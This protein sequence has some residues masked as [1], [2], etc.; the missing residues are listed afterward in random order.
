MKTITCIFSFLV[1]LIVTE[2]HGQSEITIRTV[3]LT[4][5]VAPGTD[6]AVFQTLSGG[7]EFAPALNNTG[8][9]AFNGELSGPGVTSQNKWGIWKEN[10]ELHLVVRGGDI[11]PGT[12]G[13]VFDPNVSV[14]SNPDLNDSSHV[15]FLSRLR[16]SSFDD[17][18]LSVWKENPDLQ[19]VAREGDVA[20]GTGGATFDG[21]FTWPSI[22]NS[23]NVGFQNRVLGPT[24]TSNNSGMWKEDPDLQLIVRTGDEAPG[25]DGAIFSDLTFAA[26]PSLTNANKAAFRGEFTEPGGNSGNQTGLWRETPS[27]ELIVRRFDIAPGTDGALFAY[28]T[29]GLY[30]PGSFAS[31]SMNSS[32][33]VAFFA[34]LDGP[35][36]TGDNRRSVWKERSGLELVVR[37]GDLAPGT[38]GATF[39]DFFSH[40]IAPSFN[41]KGDV[42]FGGYLYGD[43]VTDT[44]DRGIWVEAGSEGMVLVLRRGDE[45][46][47]RPGDIRTV[48]FFNL[49][50]DG[51]NNKGDVAFS[52]QFEDGSSG[53]FVASRSFLGGF[54]L[55]DI[56]GD[57]IADLIWRN[58]DSG[59][60]ATWLMNDLGQRQAAT[61]PGGAGADWAIQGVGDVNGDGQGDVVWRNKTSGATAVWLMNA[62]GNREAATFPGGASFEWAIR[63]VGDVNNDGFA[64]VVWRNTSSGATAV[65]LMNEDGLREAAT[66]PGGAGGEWVIQG[67]GDVN[68]D[69]TVDIVWRN[70]SSG[71]TAAW[72]MNTDGLRQMASFPGGVVLAWTIKGIEDVNG[73]GVGDLVWRDTISGATAVWLMDSSGLRQKAV[74]PGGAGN[75]WA[76]QQVGDVNG[77]NRADLVWRNIDTGATATW[78]MNSDGLREAATFPG[79]AGDEWQLRP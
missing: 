66:F 40:K 9:T 62:S 58:S 57:G 21:N 54:H 59:A 19:L 65:W 75:E 29:T 4:G 11:A 44:N 52:A 72:L 31:P 35:G 13:K 6:G 39:I 1:F 28:F 5:E 14:Y 46:E 77:D 32:G 24:V 69:G 8:H 27:L 70:A 3:A 18:L 53:V 56:N 12:G 47:V 10:P 33:K 30:V 22:N 42:A 23:G 71:E 36:I 68:G 38:E 55:S 20:P 34:E 43:G 45:L 63:G 50:D 37:S 49:D 41:D 48:K 76:V 15:A 17:D 73:D 16:G 60:T 2:G 26:R 61:F 64:D 78:L 25:T 67:V 74:F 79:G 7:S 51:F